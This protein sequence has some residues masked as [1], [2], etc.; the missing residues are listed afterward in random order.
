MPG[1]M[2][3]GFVS[4]ENDDLHCIAQRFWRRGKDLKITAEETQ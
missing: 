4:E 3:A 1:R 2:V